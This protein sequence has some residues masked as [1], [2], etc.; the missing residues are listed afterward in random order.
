[1]NYELN[2]SSKAKKVI[3]K[4][5]KSNPNV[6]KKLTLILEELTTHPRTGTGHPEPLKRG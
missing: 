6:F 2:F 3:D 1:M 4:W 5:K